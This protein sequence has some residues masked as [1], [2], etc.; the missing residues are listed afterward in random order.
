[1]KIKNPL[2]MPIILFMLV[3]L[4][5]RS[6]I[7]GTPT[8]TPTSTPGAGNAIGVIGASG[9]GGGGG[10]GAGG[11]GGGDGSG[12][13]SD[14]GNLPA[15]TPTP[16]PLPTPDITTGPY[17][18]EQIIS[19]GGETISGIVCDLTRPFTV[20]VVAPATPFTFNFLPSSPTAGSLT[21][22]YNLP[23]A[24]ESHDATGSYTIASP[25]TDGKRLLSMKVSDHVVF[26]GFDGNIPNNYR[27]NLVPADISRLPV[28]SV[29]MADCGM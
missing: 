8:A 10:N 28:E 5:C 20:N 27:F 23:K 26:K 12:S 1:M 3:S 25:G 29:G 2:W 17:A 14:A 7:S 18:V 22:A 16:T 24:G 9:N 11:G 4:S 13:G 21:Y 15:A 6:P 19:L